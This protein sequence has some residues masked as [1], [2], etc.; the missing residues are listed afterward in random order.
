VYFFHRFFVIAVQEEM[1]NLENC[2]TSAVFQKIQ[3]ANYFANPKQRWL[4]VHVTATCGFCP[5]S[6]KRVTGLGVVFPFD[7][8][9]PVALVLSFLE[10]E[11]HGTD[12]HCL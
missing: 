5:Q 7:S 12:Q 4:P 8:G 1:P 2:R 10:T 3:K 6:T 9:L 11:A